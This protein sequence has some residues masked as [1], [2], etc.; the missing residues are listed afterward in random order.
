MTNTYQRLA[1][2]LDSLPAGYPPS[3]DGVEIQIL[4]YLFTEEEAELALRLGLLGE[5]AP[6]IAR[7]A[8]CA[9]DVTASMLEEMVQKG[10][11][12][13]SYPEDNPPTYSISQFV[14]GFYEDQVNRLEP[15]LVDLFEAYAPIYFEEGPWK[16]FPQVRTIPVN[17]AIPITSEVLPYFRVEEILQSKAHIAVRNCVCRQE[18]ELLDQGCGKPMEACFSFD[19]AALNTVKTGKGRLVSHEEARLIIKQAQ[20]AGLVLQPANSQNPIFMCA[21]CSCCCG[22]LRHIKEEPNPGDLVANPFVAQ[23]ASEECI[24]CGAC[25]DICPMAALTLDELDNINFEQDRCIGCGL[26]VGLCPTGSIRLVRKPE[27]EQPKIPKN[28]TNTYLNIARTRGISKVLAL[29]NMLI[30]HIFGKL[31]AATSITESVKPEKE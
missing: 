21:C 20:A 26:C 24:A 12:S 6:V 27:T 29:I 17:E 28:T 10:L 18:R 25:V 4:E 1:K 22:V 16:K 19:N 3:D 8:G 15:E 31:M 14:I 30:K 13:G 9:P 11:I 23:Y 7:M 5:S 2:Y